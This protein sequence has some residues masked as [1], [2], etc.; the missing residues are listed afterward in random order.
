MLAHTPAAA[1]VRPRPGS[2][3]RVRQVYHDTIVRQGRSEGVLIS[4]SFLLTSLVIRAITHAIRDQRF[5]FLFH[6]I[7]PS[8]GLHIH[9]F[10]IG[11][12]ILLAVGFI[13]TGFRPNRPWA[14]RALAIAFGIAAALTLDEFALWLRLQDVY[15]SPQGRESVDALILT[16]AISLLAVQGFSF[17]RALWRDAIWLLLRREQAYPEP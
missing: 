14:R 15:W 16:G 9:H 7:S 8:S 12:L 13:S 4:V 2:F 11:I 17:W 10:V 1:A 3:G 6:N 5:K